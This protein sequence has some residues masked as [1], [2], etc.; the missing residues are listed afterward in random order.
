M[1]ALEK[2]RAK[3]FWRYSYSALAS[4]RAIPSSLLPAAQF[5][6]AKV[7]LLETQI[8]SKVH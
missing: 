7:Q 8:D 4:I 6:P 1:A 5:M 2:V 3:T